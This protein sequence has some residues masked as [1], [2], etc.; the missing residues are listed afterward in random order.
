MSFGGAQPR[1]PHGARRA[2]FRGRFAAASTAR[3][4]TASS[5]II[6]KCPGARRAA[7]TGAPGRAVRR[8]LAPARS[9]PRRRAARVADGSLRARSGRRRAVDKR[10]A[11]LHH[12]R[13]PEL[14]PL[15]TATST[16]QNVDDACARPSTMYEA[17]EP[18][19]A[20]RRR[21]VSP[22]KRRA[23]RLL[24]SRATTATRI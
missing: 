19:A 18:S 1:Q 6:Q 24:K 15:E 8:Q 14:D 3:A 7:R 5:R 11:T 10:A 16:L 22:V 21:T 17:V 2:R 9:A 13:R 12:R 20:R 23:E 4:A